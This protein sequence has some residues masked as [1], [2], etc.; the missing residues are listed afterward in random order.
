MFSFL[1]T[2]R[3][4]V[5]AI[6]T[7]FFCGCADVGGRVEQYT[8]KVTQM[9]ERSD[10]PEPIA[11]SLE[12]MPDDAAMVARA[13]QQRV[14]GA[15]RGR[16]QNVRFAGNIGTT[17]TQ[18]WSKEARFI[19]TGA[20]LYLHQAKADDSAGKTSSGRLDFE[21]PLGRKASVRYDAF[22]RTDGNDVLIEEA[23]VTPIYPAFPEPLLFV[24]PAKAL[25]ADANRYPGTYDALLQFVGAR[26]VRSAKTASPT[27][28]PKD[29]VI[30]VFFLDQA[31]DT[32]NISVKV[33]DESSGTQGYNESTRYVNFGGWRVALL[34]GRF[35]LFGDNT[36]QPLYVKAVFTP[37]EE[38]GFLRR[39]PKLVGVFNI[40]GS[41]P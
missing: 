4:L 29:Y 18:P 25:P 31:S 28:Q 21:G 16:V 9:I 30:F 33:S 39:A 36:S 13:I 38:V 34:A 12:Q 10:A 19:P 11:T 7:L 14:T 23:H 35:I 32:A 41:S 8:Q 15:G 26:A 2:F 37:G 22:C 3:F 1:T 40:S 20:Q 27:K 17:L 6:A 5:L 24:V